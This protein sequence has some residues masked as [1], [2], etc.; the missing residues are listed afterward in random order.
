[1]ES[2]RRSLARTPLPAQPPGPVPPGTPTLGPSAPSR[3]PS[4]PALTS[5]PRSGR[6]SPLSW[7]R[8]ALM[9]A[10]RRFSSRGFRFC[11]RARSLRLRGSQSRPPA[12]LLR[13]QSPVPASYLSQ[14]RW[15][16]CPSRQ[17]HAWQESS[18]AAGPALESPVPA[19][20]RSGDRGSQ[21]GP[22]RSRIGSQWSARYARSPALRRRRRPP[23]PGPP[24]GV[25]PPV[26]PTSRLCSCAG[27]GGR[28]NGGAPG[29][30]F[31][32]SRPICDGVAGPEHPPA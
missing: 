22:V 13:P 23:R 11:R 17:P 14:L 10:R 31:Q 6:M 20:T 30:P 5:L 4:A 7:L 15:V 9:R 16:P 27:W 28:G 32:A 25:R 19:L 18:A 26:G 29:I 21:G 12:R 2:P 1:M 3:D 24:R 8:L